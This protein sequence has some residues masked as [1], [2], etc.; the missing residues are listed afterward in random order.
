MSLKYFLYSLELKEPFGTAHGTRTHT[1]GMLVA[2]ESD[3]LTGYGEV[4]MPPYYPE[5]Q[6]SMALFFD[7]VDVPKLLR[8]ESLADRL[9]YVRSLG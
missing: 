1:H 4:F 2:I 3:G 9:A 5:N 6:E 8:T 7:S